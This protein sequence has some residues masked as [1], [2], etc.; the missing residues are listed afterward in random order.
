MLYLPITKSWIISRIAQKTYFGCALAAFALYRVV[1]A[2]KL[3]LRAVGARS[4]EVSPT[5]ATLVESMLVP[6]IVGASL[7]YIAIWYFWFNY[8]DSGLFKRTVWFLF[9]YFLFPIGAALYYFLVYR[10]CAELQRHLSNTLHHSGS[11]ARRPPFT[12]V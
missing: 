8:D 10:R 4:F 1:L 3:A 5:A 12:K 7:L 9:L 2:S 11:C 6:G